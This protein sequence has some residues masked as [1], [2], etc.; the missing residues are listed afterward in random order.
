MHTDGNLPLAIAVIGLLLIV[1]ALLVYQFFLAPLPVT[2]TVEMKTVTGTVG[3]TSRTVLTV[4]AN[5]TTVDDVSYQAMLAGA[6]VINGTV[7]DRLGRDYRV[8]SYVLTLRL[9]DG[10]PVN[11]V[12][13]G[14]SLTYTV[15]RETFNRVAVGE[16]VTGSVA[17]TR[18]PTLLAV[19]P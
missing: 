6:A 17:R 10:D 4:T 11:G 1:P 8:V 2:G 5:G 18:S 9:P 15:D 3:D 7:A 12:P 14:G 19:R 16:S 13:R